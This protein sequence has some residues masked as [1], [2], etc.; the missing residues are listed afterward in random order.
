MYQCSIA[1]SR[2]DGVHLKH[3]SCV[4]VVLHDSYYA[5]FYCE[6]MKQKKILVSIV[7]LM[8]SCDFLA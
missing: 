2:Y 5:L 1:S 6:S 3:C 7:T 4:F 8:Y